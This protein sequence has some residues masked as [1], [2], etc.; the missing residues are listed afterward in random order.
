MQHI[1]FCVSHAA[2]RELVKFGLRS[3]TV[4]LRLAAVVGRE[5][6]THDRIN[7]QRSPTELQPSERKRRSHI[8]T[9]PGGLVMGCQAVSISPGC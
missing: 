8:F 9:P 4:K 2:Y 1:C 6:A 5:R 3:Q 7:R